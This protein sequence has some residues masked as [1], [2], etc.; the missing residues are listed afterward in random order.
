MNWN[1]NEMAGAFPAVPE[2]FQSAMDRAYDAIRSEA[3]RETPRA[4]FLKKRPMVWIAAAVLTLAVTAGIAAGL[5]TGVLDFLKAWYGPEAVQPG[6]DALVQAHLAQV[7]LPETELTVREALYDGNNLRVVY[8]VRV[9]ALKAM[10]TEEDLNDPNGAFRQA[11]A[12]DGVNLGGGDWFTLNGADYSMTNGATM[13][14]AIG[15]QPGELL[16]YVDIPLAS[17]GIH[18]QADPADGTLEVGMA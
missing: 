16:V 8:S 2:A 1:S 4:V 5:R 7:S 12:R 10:L 15:D 13:E 11:V 14:Q 17:A 6:A 18:P 3:Q 9:K